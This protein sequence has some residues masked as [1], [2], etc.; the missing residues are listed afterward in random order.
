MI[1]SRENILNT[2]KFF[3]F[4]SFGVVI[5]IGATISKH[6]EKFKQML[7]LALP[8]NFKLVDNQI[9]AEHTFFIEYTSAKILKMFQNGEYIKEADSELRFFNYLESVV[10]LTVGE[11]AKAKLFLHAGVVAINGR[12]LIIPAKSFRGK[13]TLVKEL[14]LR[15]AVYYSDEYAI[16]DE[17]GLVYP[18]PKTL[19]VRGI[20]D[21]YQ[22]LEVSVES[23]GGKAGSG[24]CPVGMVLITEY[25]ADAVWQPQRLSAGAGIME[26]IPHTLAIRKQTKFALQVLKNLASRAIICKSSRGE[27]CDF[28]E[29]II[30]FFEENA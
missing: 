22:Q 9:S 10:R 11:H 2:D 1:K 4:E 30:E 26:I 5:R 28:A 17:N 27:A 24:P 6:S 12:A 7:K 3:T 29:K 25:S 15:G 21:E 16:L 18:F 19:S 8:E 20:T 13:T 14:V 23:L